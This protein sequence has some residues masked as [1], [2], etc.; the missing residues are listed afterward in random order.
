MLVH[1]NTPSCLYHAVRCQTAPASRHP[2]FVLAPCKQDNGVQNVLADVIQYHPVSIRT[3]TTELLPL[4]NAR[5]VGVA[6]VERHAIDMGHD[7]VHV[8]PILHQKR[9]ALIEH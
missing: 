7:V 6:G 8:V 3:T 4:S 1:S 2:T 9:F 5:E